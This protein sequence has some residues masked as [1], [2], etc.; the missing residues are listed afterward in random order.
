MRV[1]RTADEIVAALDVIA[2]LNVDD[3][4]LRDEIFRQ[5]AAIL[6][7]NADLALGF[8]VLAEHDPARSP[9][10]DGIFLGDAG[11]EQLGNTRQTAGDVARLGGF[12][13]D[14]GENVARE[15]RR[16]VFD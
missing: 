3:F 13:A 9:R 15:H 2:F 1:G 11:F 4:R 16:T 12:T 10:D 6:G 5:L 8:I 14:T 7:L